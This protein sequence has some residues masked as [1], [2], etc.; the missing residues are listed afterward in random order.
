MM[1][2][3]AD[4]LATIRALGG[5]DDIRVNDVP[6][7]GLFEIEPSRSAFDDISVNAPRP[8]L[9]CLTSVAKSNGFKS[10]MRVF[11][12][13]DEAAYFIADI[14]DESGVSVIE[15]RKE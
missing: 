8:I 10:G 4:R 6:V 13:D 5:S 2:S 11:V 1:E 15:L 9:R 14:E 3:D 7:T 12:P